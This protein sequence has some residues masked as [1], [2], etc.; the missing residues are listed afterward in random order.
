MQVVI[1]IDDDHV[2]KDFMSWLCGSGE[3]MYWEDMILQEN[4]VCISSF[5]YDFNNGIIDTNIGSL[6][7]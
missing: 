1:N 4:S 5:K 3:Q 2:A 6:D 7:E